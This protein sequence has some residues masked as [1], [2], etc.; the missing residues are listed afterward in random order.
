MGFAVLTKVVESLANL[1]LVKSKPSFRDRKSGTW[2]EPVLKGN[3]KFSLISSM[4]FCGL[5]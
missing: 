4:T 1:I 5:L 3:R 2:N